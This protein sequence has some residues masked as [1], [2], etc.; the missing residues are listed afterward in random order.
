MKRFRDRNPLTVGLVTIVVA[1]AAVLG[2]LNFSKLSFFATPTYQAY[3]A[4]SAGL[5]KGDLVM[6]AGVRVGQVTGLAL[7]GDQV[8]VSFTVS[9]GVQLGT[10]TAASAA[11]FTPVGQE[12]L[13][14]KPAGP[15]RLSP[16]TAIPQSRTSAPSTLV[17]DLSQFTTQTQRYN[18][19][20]LVKALEVSSQDLQGTPA[21]V[22]AAAL[23]GL[24]RFSL[25]LADRQRDLSTLISQGALVTGILSQRSQE[26]VSLVGQSNLVLLVLDQRRQEV[27]QLLASTAALSQQLSTI[28]HGDSAQLGTLLSNLQTVSAL[29]ARD[30]T[31][32]GNAI[33]VLAAF[34]RYT[35]NVTGSGPFAD[36]VVPTMLIPD[37]VI[38]QCAKQLPLDPIQGCQQ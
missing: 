22:T 27:R 19:A 20:Q 11:V 33:P 12:Y 30:A 35:A 36:V 38:A 26:L 34:D 3:F 37:N 13:A 5:Q 28:V 14:V 1:V 10:D 17:S 16:S 25:V 2:A 23:S 9:R 4:N 29:L 32:L 18:I 15:G 7:R 6:V 31:T 24:A 21:N 8:V